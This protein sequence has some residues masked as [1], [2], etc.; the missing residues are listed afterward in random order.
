MSSNNRIEYTG[1]TELKAALRSLPA[2]LARLGN[3]I[4]SAHTQAAYDSIRALYPEVTGTL[5]QRM[6]IDIEQSAF[7]TIGRVR[8]TAPHAWLYENGS[9]TRQTALGYNRGAMPPNNV[10]IPEA[11][12]K[13]RAMVQQLIQ[14]VNDQGLQVTGG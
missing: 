13:R 9:Q 8:S 11:I 12:R 5:K 10:F 3:V 7:G 4:V 6:R 1:L 2:D 14:L